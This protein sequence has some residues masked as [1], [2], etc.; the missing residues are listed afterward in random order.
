MFIFDI[1]IWIINLYNLSK[2]VLLIFDNG[3]DICFYECI[4]VNSDCGGWR[5]LVWVLELI[6]WW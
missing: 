5:K 1:K 4:F 6:L 3:V 2:N